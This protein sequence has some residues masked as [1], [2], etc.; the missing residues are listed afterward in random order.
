MRLNRRVPVDTHGGMR[1][2]PSYLEGFLLDWGTVGIQLYEV[3]L[4]FAHSMNGMR[5]CFFGRGLSRGRFSEVQASNPCWQRSC[6]PE[7]V[8]RHRHSTRFWKGSW[9]ARASGN[10]ARTRHPRPVFLLRP[11]VPSGLFGKWEFCPDRFF[12]I[13][14]SP[15]GREFPPWRP[16][17]NFQ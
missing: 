12:H 16:D 1:G 2:R 10:C 3:G 15:Q 13:R 7:S 6:R 14:W 4:C 9:P 17:Q 5:I 8:W 11:A